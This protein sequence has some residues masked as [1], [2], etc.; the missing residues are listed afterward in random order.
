MAVRF[1]ITA[2][3][4]GAE[5]A[6]KRL[7]RKFRGLDKTTKQ[8]ERSSNRSIK[9]MVAGYATLGLGIGSVLLAGR[10]LGRFVADSV[11]AAGVQ[12]QAEAKRRAA[13][14]ASGQATEDVI[15][16]LDAQALALQKLTGRGDEETLA[17]QAQ[18]IQLGVSLDKMEEFTLAVENAAA[19]GF[20][21]ETITRG[22]A[23]SF[24]GSA[25]MLS[26]YVPEL[27]ELTTEQLKSG[28]A[29]R[30]FNERFA[31]TAEA[32]ASTWP[33][34]V[35]KLKGAWSDFAKEGLGSVITKSPVARAAMVELA[36]VMLDSTDKMIGAQAA[37]TKSTDK[38]V[39]TIIDGAELAAKG[40]STL[41]RAWKGARATAEAFTVD[42][43]Q[44]RLAGVRAEVE[45]LQK[46][47]VVGDRA[48]FAFGR[49]MS[50]AQ[51]QA[52]IERLTGE[53]AKLEV[54]VEEGSL[55]ADDMAKA[56]RD[57]ADDTK[58]IETAFE[59]FREA[60]AELA[61][62]LPD[63][64]S[65]IEKLGDDAGETADKIDEAADATRRL[66]WWEEKRYSSTSDLFNEMR[67]Q[68]RQ[69]A[70]EARIAFEDQI[71][72]SQ[73]LGE[74]IGNVGAAFA[75]GQTAMDGL[76]NG[77]R[78]A[79][80]LGVEMIGRW[81]IAQ[82]TAQQATTASTVAGAAQQTAALGPP[83]VLGTIAS[84]GANIPLAVGALSAGIAL[85]AGLIGAIGDRG[86]MDAPGAGR[87]TVSKRGDELLMDPTGTTKLHDVLDSTM[88]I[89]RNAG[90]GVLGGIA[91][92]V[93]G[94][95]RLLTVRVPVVLDGR[96]IGEVVDTVLAE[97][98]ED[99]S[100]SLPYAMGTV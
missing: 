68:Q 50:E 81:A 62:D 65:G 54:Q 44:S 75:Q 25:G 56:F 38:V 70:E 96:V 87:M 3:G 97:M 49:S 63:A 34:A 83:A 90:G 16:M 11:R 78:E 73:R 67:D 80:Q 5:Q 94:A 17:L 32:A 92:D 39:Y 31:G 35:N 55:A 6:V 100:S 45:R 99:G 64:S 95:G 21:L 72:S 86:I 29:V 93:S 1:T 13:L 58:E 60:V 33:G 36:N 19:A 88:A 61:A 48:F 51:R 14:E 28:E 89:V 22:L 85:M 98:V 27:R 37:L 41:S 53:I 7:G 74:S 84:A 47:T 15:A 91:D 43:L 9:K 79:G 71:Q 77:L 24:A 4:K 12:A 46:A 2:E 40:V 76:K 57:G 66:M 20:P 8:T 23:A 18:A 10:R 30:L 26:R 82:I 52:Q 69:Q 59:N 42:I